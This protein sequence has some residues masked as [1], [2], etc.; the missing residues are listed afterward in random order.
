MSGRL[1]EEQAELAELL[2][3]NG[4]GGASIDTGEGRRDRR[5]S[6]KYAGVKYDVD[7]DLSDEESAQTIKANRT[8]QMAQEM[9]TIRKDFVLDAIFGRR[10]NK[11]T[12]CVEYLCKFTNLSHLHLRWLTYE[13]VEVFFPEGYIMR[14]KVL[15]YDKKLLKDG[16]AEQDEV[17]DLDANNTLVEKIISHQVG[18]NNDG[19]DKLIDDRRLNVAYQRK[20]PRVTDAFLIEN[21]KDVLDRCTGILRKLSADP[22]ADIFLQPVDVSYVLLFRAIFYVCYRL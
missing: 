13:E 14:N 9:N 8:A 21:S 4:T 10:I 16:Y 22:N 6:A 2:Q 17:D 20:Y 15:M 1:T 3:E 19:L 11:T 7:L 18:V 12:G 5:R